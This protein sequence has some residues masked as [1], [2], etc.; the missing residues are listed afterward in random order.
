[1]TAVLAL[2]Y[3][4]GR[5]QEDPQLFVGVQPDQVWVGLYLSPA[6]LKDDAPMAGAVAV[7]P[8]RV[9]ELGRSVGVGA[10]LTLATC[11]R[12]GEIEHRPAGDSAA[13]Y[14]A[15][16]HLCALRVLSPDEVAADGAGFVDQTGTLLTR[17]VPL[18]KAYLE[19][20]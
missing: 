20:L 12:Y 4:V 6:L 11:K 7:A 18:W 5:K 13:D 1:V 17:L 9:V 10:E 8:E 16:P 2:F 3:R 15:G 19:G 14:L